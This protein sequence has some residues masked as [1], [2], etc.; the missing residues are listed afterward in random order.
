VSL[1]RFS[2]RARTDASTRFCDD[3]RPEIGHEVPRL[4]A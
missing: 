3:R 4:R 1:S 2:E